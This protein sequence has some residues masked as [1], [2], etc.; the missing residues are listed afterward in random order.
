V[1]RRNAAITANQALP[2]E[3]IKPQPDKPD[4]GIDGSIGGRPEGLLLDVNGEPIIL[5]PAAPGTLRTVGTRPA[6]QLR[7][8][9]ARPTNRRARLPRFLLVP[10]AQ[11]VGEYRAELIRSALQMHAIRVPTFVQFWRPFSLDLV[12]GAKTHQTVRPVGGNC[13][14]SAQP[15]QHAIAASRETFKRSAACNNGARL[16]GWAAFLRCFYGAIWRT[17]VSFQSTNR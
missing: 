12:T 8:S 11:S 9:M 3:R 1:T 6:D 16:G 5:P 10:K 15:I 2:G 4:H 13:A 14:H 17:S 7:S